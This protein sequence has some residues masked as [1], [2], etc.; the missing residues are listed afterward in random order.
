MDFQPGRTDVI[1]HKH[2]D[3]CTGHD[4]HYAYFIEEKLEGNQRRLPRRSDIYTES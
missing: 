3:W 2:C 1:S 4:I